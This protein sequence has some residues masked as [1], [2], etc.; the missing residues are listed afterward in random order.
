MFQREFAWTF[1]IS[2]ATNIV[3]GIED[4]LY[5]AIDYIRET[6]DTVIE[7]L[8]SVVRSFNHTT[9]HGDKLFKLE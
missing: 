1:E 5:E 3:E 2:M 6:Y 4:R 7:I 9:K 8:P